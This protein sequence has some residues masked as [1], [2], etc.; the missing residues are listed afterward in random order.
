MLASRHHVCAST[1]LK[2]DSVRSQYQLLQPRLGDEVRVDV[3][4]LFPKFL[5]DS[6]PQTKRRENSILIFRTLMNS[7]EI[8]FDVR[9]APAVANYIP[10]SSTICHFTRC[11]CIVPCTDG[12][13]QAIGP[14]MPGLEVARAGPKQQQHIHS[15]N[16]IRS[17]NFWCEF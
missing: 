8:I 5:Y 13:G 12:D 11:M 17:F 15:K 7:L 9:I 16:T 3:G 1:S 10:T 14:P 6:P 4:K 2:T